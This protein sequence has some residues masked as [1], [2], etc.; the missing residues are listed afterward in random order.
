M[1][2]GNRRDPATG[3]KQRDKGPVTG[4]RGP[5]PERRNGAI[6]PKGRLA[7]QRSKKK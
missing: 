4:R 7:H 3:R 2:S 5:R 1:G 6:V